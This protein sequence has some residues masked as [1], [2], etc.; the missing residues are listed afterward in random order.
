MSI[1]INQFKWLPFVTLLLFFSETAQAKPLV[2][3]VVPQQSPLTLYKNWKPVVD[4]L[5]KHTGLEI[6][7]RTEK[8]IAEFERRLYDGQ[9]DLAYMNPYHYIVANNR[10]GYQAVLRR[11]GN[12]RGILVAKKGSSL[13]IITKTSRFLFPSPNAFAATLV[14][15]YELIKKFGLNLEIQKNY[16]YV[17]SHDS[18]YKGVARGIGQVG[19]GVQ[20]TFNSFRSKTDKAQLQVLYTTAAYP[21]HPFAFKP[22]V[23]DKDRQAIS[24][25]ISSLPEALLTSLSMKKIIATTDA[26]YDIIREL[27]ASLATTER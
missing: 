11:Q 14:T 6:I 23:S 15:K 12:I 27:S 10:Q 1:L 24:K 3:G 22:N 13:D 8:T 18:V 16:D 20:R 2:I 17:N 26:E 25:A 4:Y 19:G 9:Y 7:F 5:S 21:S